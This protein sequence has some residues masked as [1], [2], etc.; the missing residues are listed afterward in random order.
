MPKSLHGTAEGIKPISVYAGSVP[1]QNDGAFIIC[2]GFFSLMNVIQMLLSFMLVDE[3]NQLRMCKH[4]DKVFVGTRSNAAFCS[5]TC[6]NRY[7][8]YKSRERKELEEE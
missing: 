5:P 4:C 2:W 3:E 1:E 8:V 6:K 7:N